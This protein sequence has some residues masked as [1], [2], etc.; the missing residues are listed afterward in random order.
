MTLWKA[1]RSVSA[2]NLNGNDAQFCSSLYKVETEHRHSTFLIKF[3]DV[4]MR[5][6]H[7]VYKK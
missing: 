7:C 3:R 1:Y 2:G 5:S 4:Q 6:L